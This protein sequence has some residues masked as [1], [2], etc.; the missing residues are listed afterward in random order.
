LER[1]KAGEGL[2]GEA[3]G[4]LRGDLA[5]GRVASLF[6]EVG[7]VMALLESTL[8]RVEGTARDLMISPPPGVSP[9][10]AN[11]ARAQEIGDAFRV[12]LDASTIARRTIRRV[13]MHPVYGL[14]PGEVD[15][16]PDLREEFAS[17]GGVDR[18]NLKLL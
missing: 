4:D 1:P 11:E 3:S 7:D 17:R 8:G 18:M 5:L 12:L 9:D 10:I 2:P 14:G 15:L 6:S 16:P 13:L